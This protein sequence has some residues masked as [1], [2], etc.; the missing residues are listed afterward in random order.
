[1]DKFYKN[2]LVFGKDNVIKLNNAKIVVFG[3]GGVGSY[4]AEALCRSGVGNIILVDN[5]VIDITNINRQIHTNIDT[6][7]LFKVDVMKERINKINPECNVEI[8]KQF[9]LYEDDVDYIDSSVDYIVDAV[10]TVTAKIGLVVLADKY[11]IPIISCM[12]TGNKLNPTMLEVEDIYKTSV[13]PLAKVM[14]KE[15]KA[16]NIK[17]LKVVYSKEYPIKNNNTKDEIGSV[18]FVPSVAGIIIASEVVKSLINE[19][20]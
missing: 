10:D 5:D 14:R 3:I 4:V 6:V 12:G 13:C 7:G 15:L 20:K 8:K 19:E 17:K 9:F 11:N 1:M 16:R 2:E 18:C